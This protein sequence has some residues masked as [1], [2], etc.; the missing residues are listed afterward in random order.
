[1][2]RIHEKQCPS[3]GAPLPVQAGLPSVRCQ[4]CGTTVQVEYTRRERAPGADTPPTVYVAPGLPKAAIVGIVLSAMLPMG[5]AGVTIFGSTISSAVKS[6]VVTFPMDCGN[7]ESL[8]I[9]GTTYSGPGPLV[10]APMNC[11]LTVVDSK[12]SSDV[13]VQ[14]GVNTEVTVENATLDA[15]DVA[16]RFQ[17]NGTLHASGNCLVRGKSA[18]IAGGV[19]T[20]IDLEDAR[21]EGGDVGIS[22]E[23]NAEIHATRAAIKGHDAAIAVGTNGHVFGTSLSVEGDLHGIDGDTNLELSFE[24]STL[25]AGDVGVRAG[26]NFHARLTKQSHIAG[27]TTAVDAGD[28]L[29]LSVQES[30]IDSDDTGARTRWNP[31][32]KVL[33]D[34]KLHGGRVALE[35][36]ENLDLTVEQGSIESAGTA[37][38]GKHNAEIEGRGGAISGAAAL[39]FER[40]PAE[41]LV[42]TTVTGARVYDGK[43]CGAP[44]PPVTTG[45]TQ[46]LAARAP[47]GT[48]LHAPRPTS[49]SGPTAPPFDAAA[50]V[51][52][53][54][55][56]SRAASAQCRS[57]SGKPEQL[58]MAPGFDSEGRNSGATATT[59]HGSAEAA[60]AER[61]FRSVRIPPFDP[62]TRPAGLTRTISLK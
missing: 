17:T 52:A 14:G 11:K 9:A 57:S 55:A 23:V 26:S 50:A 34:G 15:T 25:S 39:R 48:P 29:E 32:V 19:N 3:C 31:H 59:L 10:R 44:A 13:I 38:C 62:A 43:G 58:S 46:P 33:R 24:Q 6:T 7:N 54:D 28:N 37:I 2:P 18:A 42:G 56:A 4:Y 53:L 51:I 45:D 60:C 1:M 12:L 5:I 49:P 36:G 30:S 41:R 16:V 61:I 20:K 22:G 40:A 21:V 35:A 8:R 27:K 47:S